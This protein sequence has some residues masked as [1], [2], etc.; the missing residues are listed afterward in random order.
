[1][2]P[3]LIIPYFLGLLIFTLLS[4]FAVYRLVRFGRRTAGNWAILLFFSIGTAVVIIMTLFLFSTINWSD[5]QPL[6]PGDFMP[7]L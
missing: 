3:F 7:N 4:I 6:I 1:M 5:P 2:L